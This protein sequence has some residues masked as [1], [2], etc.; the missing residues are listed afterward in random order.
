M[1]DARYYKRHILENVVK[2]QGQQMYNTD[3]WCFQQDSAPAHK[4]DICQK[5]CRENLPDF[6]SRDE[7]PPSSPDL[8]PLDYSIWGIL[9]ARV[10]STRHANIESLK[11]KLIEEWDNLSMDLVRTAIDSWPK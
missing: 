10:N 5:W 2:P 6:I 3:N 7:W 8:N 4:A 11:S 9:E 1:L